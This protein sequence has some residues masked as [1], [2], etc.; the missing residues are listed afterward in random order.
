MGEYVDA[1]FSYKI[2]GEMSVA[3]ILVLLDLREGLSPEICLNTVYGDVVQVLDYE[4][5]P[6]HYHHSHSA[7]HLVVQCDRPFRG[8]I[9][10]DG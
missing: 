7:N 4:G 5:V 1:D 6:F 8:H 10:T 9:R 3:R 2:T